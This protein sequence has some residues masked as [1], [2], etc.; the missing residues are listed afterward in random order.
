MMS[1]QRIAADTGRRNPFTATARAVALG[2]C[3]MLTG[4]APS[5]TPDERL[6][7]GLHLRINL[8]RALV[9]LGARLGV[10][11]RGGYLMQVVIIGEQGD[12]IGRI[13]DFQTDQLD[14][15]QGSE[16]FLQAIL[17]ICGLER[18]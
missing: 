17:N 10:G 6:N 1:E 14:Y 16:A 7:P 5:V 12:E 8:D 11:I 4:F 2:T 15:E 18:D 9:E 3:S 13:T